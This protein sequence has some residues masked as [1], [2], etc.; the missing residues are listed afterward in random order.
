MIGGEREGEEE[1]RKEDRGVSKN[2]QFSS[3][4]QSSATSKEYKCT[5]LGTAHFFVQKK[6]KTSC[7]VQYIQCS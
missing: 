3:C 1:K 7:L 6:S 5:P 4:V 2:S